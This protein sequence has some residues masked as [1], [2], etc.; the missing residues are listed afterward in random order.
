MDTRAAIVFISGE[1]P[2][3]ACLHF[4]SISVTHGSERGHAIGEI[5]RVSSFRW[6]TV[7]PQGLKI[8]LSLDLIDVLIILPVLL[9]GRGSFKH[10]YT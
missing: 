5:A 10:V 4:L 8:Y 7:N 9:M 2:T 1:T 6:I 3:L